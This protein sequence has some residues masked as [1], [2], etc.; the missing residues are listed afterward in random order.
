MADSVSK[1][2]RSEIMRQVKGR[3]T[4]PEMS[5]RK[6]LWRRGIRGWRIHQKGLPG[7]P[8]V[9]FNKY[10]LAIFVDGCFWHGCSNC[11]RRPK[12]RQDYWDKKLLKNVARDRENDRALFEL[13]W[14]VLRFWEHEVIKDID[15]CILSVVELLNPSR[16]Q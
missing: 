8:D 2:K 13:G 5:L 6:A 9:V 15:T 4:T 1:N 3:D 14:V 7:S 12:S 10:K 11:Y 16:R